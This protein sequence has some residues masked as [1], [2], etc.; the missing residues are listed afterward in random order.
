MVENEFT[1]EVENNTSKGVDEDNE[2]I[3]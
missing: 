3:N 2:P 1:L